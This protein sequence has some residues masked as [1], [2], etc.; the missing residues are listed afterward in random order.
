MKSNDKTRRGEAPKTI[1]PRSK[2]E[3]RERDESAPQVLAAIVESSD[4]AIIGKTLDGIVTSWNPSAERIFGYAASE[5][6][7][8]PGEMARI[9]DR[10]R[11]GER[12]EHHETERVRKDGRI[13]QVSLT[14]SPIHD[15]AGRI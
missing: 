3:P 11:R 4:A 15:E 2:T 9:L 1:R 13:I 10:I 12:I 8:R 14:V 6:I 5:M 7:R